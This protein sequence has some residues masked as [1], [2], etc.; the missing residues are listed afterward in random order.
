MLLTLNVYV[1]IIIYIGG[2]EMNTK[3]DLC[4]IFKVSL[5]SVNNWIKDGK[6]KTIKIGKCV[7]IPEEEVERLKRGE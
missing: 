1:C 2:D 6:I 5:S 3:S 7:R 4:Q